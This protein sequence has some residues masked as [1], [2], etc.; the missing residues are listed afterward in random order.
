MEAAIASA[1][2]QIAFYASTPAYL[3][4]LECHGWESLQQDA[5]TMMREGKWAELN[6]LIDDDILNTFAV[7]GTP[8]EVAT[9]IA[10][11]FGGKVDRISPVIYQPDVPL[12]SE[13][14][15]EIAAAV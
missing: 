7:V 9:K 6:N 5:N 4:V 1:R 15:N 12:L 14:R 8:A 10:D 13:L 2:N 11:R 3:P